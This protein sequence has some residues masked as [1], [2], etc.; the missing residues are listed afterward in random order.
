MSGRNTLDGRSLSVTT[1]RARRKRKKNKDNLGEETMISVAY[2]DDDENLAYVVC[3]LCERCGGVSMHACSS[4][5]DALKWLSHHPADVIVTD[6]Q[7]SGMNGIEL[8]KK[9]RESGNTTPCIIFTGMEIE[10]VIREAT[11]QSIGIFGYLTKDYPIRRLIPDLMELI[12]R[13]AVQSP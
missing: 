3:R 1:R 12:V 9:I 5:E 2:I 4:G 11:L 13:A 10:S 7:M 6:F 8:V